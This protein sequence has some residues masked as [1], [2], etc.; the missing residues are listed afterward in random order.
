MRNVRKWWVP[1]GDVVFAAQRNAAYEVCAS[2]LPDSEY[3]AG[4]WSATKLVYCRRLLACPCPPATCISG[5]TCSIRGTNAVSHF[6]YV[7]GDLR[8]SWEG[9]PSSVTV[10][11]WNGPRRRA[12]LEWFATGK[13][14]G[15]CG[16]I[17]TIRPIRMERGRRVGSCLRRMEFGVCRA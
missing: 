16:V 1:T 6:Y 5:A 14:A 10:M 4:E 8:G 17:L 9:L 12:S 11:N 3:T 15:D 2:Y 13:Q 7:E